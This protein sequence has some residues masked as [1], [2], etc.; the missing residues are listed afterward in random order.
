[1]EL[2]A[3]VGPG[4]LL[5]ASS[6][7]ALEDVASSQEAT[8]TIQ[9][10]PEVLESIVALKMLSEQNVSRYIYCLETLFDGSQTPS[11]AAREP[12]LQFDETGAPSPSEDKMPRLHADVA[13]LLGMR[14]N[15]ASFSKAMAS[16]RCAR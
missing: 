8:L 15:G 12:S 5:L 13:D 1:M 11:A 6:R 3:S 16:C 7:V 9:R 10:I 14:G 4:A 2:A